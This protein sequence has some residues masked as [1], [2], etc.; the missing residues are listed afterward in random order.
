MKRLN[1]KCFLQ[2]SSPKLSQNQR[3]SS[4]TYYYLL[5]ITNSANLKILQHLVNFIALTYK[6]PNVH[7]CI[8]LANV[9]WGLNMWNHYSRHAWGIKYSME[10]SHQVRPKKIV[11]VYWLIILS[12]AL[13]ERFYIFSF[14]FITTLW[15]DYCLSL[16]FQE[17]ILKFRE[18]KN[19]PSSLN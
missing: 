9:F 6:L 16:C 11:T 2:S 18:I 4:V 14:N 17:R 19:L 8:Y 13:R 1:I 7:S 12:Q 5:I 3:F 10:S 15:G